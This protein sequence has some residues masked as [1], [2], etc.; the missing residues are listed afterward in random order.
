MDMNIFDTA[1]LELVKK[2]YYNADKVEELAAYTQAEFEKLS[3]ENAELKS[4][5]EALSSQKGQISDTLMSAQSIARQIIED[6]KLQAE[7]TARLAQ[8]QAEET[9]KAAEKKAELILAG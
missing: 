9:V 6:A 3:R 5:L 7:E 8:S 4:Q 2:K 1:G